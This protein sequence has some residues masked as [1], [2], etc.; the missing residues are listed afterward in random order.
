V[1]LP[2]DRSLIGRGEVDVVLTVDGV[3][4]NTVR[5]NIK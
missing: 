5:V 2:I 4:A 3:A 1:N